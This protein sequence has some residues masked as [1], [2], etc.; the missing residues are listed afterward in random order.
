[1][2]NS[3]DH[4]PSGGDIPLTE[5][6]RGVPARVVGLRPGPHD[7]A[8][9]LRLMALGFIEGEPLRVLAFGHP[10]HDP[11]GVRLGGRGGA[12]AFA[13][14]RAEAALVRVCPLVAGRPQRPERP[15][16]PP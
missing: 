9:A 10:G 14:R 6:P 5:L 3:S 2:Q 12:G 16:P 4:Q 8:L 15:E 13:L 11:I 1:M 7:E